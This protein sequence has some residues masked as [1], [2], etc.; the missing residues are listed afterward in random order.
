MV[1]PILIAE[2]RIAR[3]F[4]RANAVRPA[5]AIPFTASRRLY[6]RAFARLREAG[7]MIE[8]GEDRWYLDPPLYEDSRVARRERAIALIA[9]MILVAAAAGF[10]TGSWFPTP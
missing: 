4:M 2:R 5:D 10:F 6:E 8:A 3:Q 1:P 9:V 7:V